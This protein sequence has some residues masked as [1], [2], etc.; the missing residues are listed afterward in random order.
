MFNFDLHLGMRYMPQEPQRSVSNLP[1][2]RERGYRAGG[3]SQGS[4][5]AQEGSS[6]YSG[7]ARTQGHYP[8]QSYSSRPPPPSNPG[9]V[10]RAPLN[11]PMDPGYLS[12]TYHH[13]G[14]FP[15]GQQYWSAWEDNPRRVGSS[16]NLASTSKEP[17]AP[18]H[19]ER[20]LRGP[21][22]Q[23]SNR[24]PQ[25]SGSQRPQQS[26][27]QH[28][29]PSTSGSQIPL[30]SSVAKPGGALA[31]D[32]PAEEREEFP[33]LVGGLP[34]IV[35]VKNYQYDTEGVFFLPDCI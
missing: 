25:P 15:P 33:L 2:P 7:P 32:S 35:D 27:H 4:P 29:M 6:Q 13:A 30:Q 34:L 23:G 3:P 11:V 8:Q 16:S 21:E 17:Y 22:L 1:D 10:S 20:P 26:S 12:G 24:P 28:R 5:Y 14:N 18:E 9:F 31:M 19:F